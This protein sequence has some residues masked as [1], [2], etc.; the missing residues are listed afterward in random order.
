MSKRRDTKTLARWNEET[1]RWATVAARQLALDLYYGR[2][3][4]SRPYDVG[5]VLDVGEKGVG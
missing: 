5:V 3:T 1:R 2:E 4:E